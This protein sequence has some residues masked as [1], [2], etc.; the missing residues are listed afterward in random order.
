[1]AATIKIGSLA[2][3]CWKQLRRAGEGA[4]NRS[5][6]MDTGNC[7]IDLVCSLAE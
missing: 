1:M 6:H 3:D 5:W 4:V 2:S 7:I